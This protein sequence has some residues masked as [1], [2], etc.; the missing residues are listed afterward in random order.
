MSAP[1][2]KEARRW[3]KMYGELTTRLYELKKIIHNVKENFDLEEC[4]ECD[5]LR[6]IDDEC[7]E[8]GHL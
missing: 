4:Q 3:K 6:H 1:R 8:C 7:K 5:N 2:S